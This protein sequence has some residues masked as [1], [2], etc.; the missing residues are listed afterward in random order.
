MFSVSFFMDAATLNKIVKKKKRKNFISK[1]NKLIFIFY[2]YCERNLLVRCGLVENR[3]RGF[4]LE[5]KRLKGQHTRAITLNSSTFLHLILSTKQ[6]LAFNKLLIV[7][8]T[9][10]STRDSLQKWRFDLGILSID[11]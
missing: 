3:P 5:V 9:N 6:K 8:A 2:R 1:L 4:R 11:I 7:C 10:S